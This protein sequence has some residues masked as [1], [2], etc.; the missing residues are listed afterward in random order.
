MRSPFGARRVVWDTVSKKSLHGAEQ[1]RADI[2][3]RR[4]AWVEQTEDVDPWRLIFLDES[5]AKTNMTRGYGWGIGGD[6]V[7][8]A[9][10]HGHWQTTTMLAAI[11]VDEVIGQAC[12]ALEGPMSGVVFSQYVEQMLVPALKPSD[13]M[14]MDNLASHK[15]KRVAEAIEAAGA[16]LWYLPPYSPDLNPIERMWS[17]VKHLI[18]KAKARAQTTLYD[19]ISQALRAVEP[20]ELTHYCAAAGYAIHE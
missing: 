14:V 1:D 13:I 18:R 5:G 11:R 4:E 10:P 17:K 12:L 2:V 9:V 15:V 8:D 3:E 19:V 16:Q 20:T 6:R 7:V